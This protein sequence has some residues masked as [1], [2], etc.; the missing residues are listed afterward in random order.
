LG[1]P[2]LRLECL[3][4]SI[5]KTERPAAPQPPPARA[6]SFNDP[7]ATLDLV[8]QVRQLATLPFVLGSRYR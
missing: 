3:N 2:V 7:Y 6:G 5:L 4:P 8:H 1:A